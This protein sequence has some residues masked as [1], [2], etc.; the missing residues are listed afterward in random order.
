[1]RLFE[2]EDKN[3]TVERFMTAAIVWFLLG[4][5]RVAAG[6]CASQLVFSFGWR[7]AA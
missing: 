3:R 6:V 7:G 1:M 2:S 4:S 5:W